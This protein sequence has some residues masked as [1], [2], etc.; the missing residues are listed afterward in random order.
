MEVLPVKP[1]LLAQLRKKLRHL[2]GN[3]LF[4][5]L[6]NQKVLDCS[7]RKENI[8]L[9]LINSWSWHALHKHRLSYRMCSH[10]NAEEGNVFVWGYGILGK[11][12]N[13]IE[14]AVPEMIPPSLFGWSDF[15][16]DIRVAHVRCGLSHFAAL[17]SKLLV[18]LFWGHRAARL[19]VVRRKK[20]PPV[21]I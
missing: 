10:C 9:D 18:L 4:A 12:P 13:L 8:P 17:T 20:I 6:Y 3:A 7:G 15:N 2:D 5:N 1:D 11:G 14:T 19:L 21:F 16:P